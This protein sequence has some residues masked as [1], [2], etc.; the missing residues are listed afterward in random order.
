M[1]G[2]AAAGPRSACPRWATA[3]ASRPIQP[4][5]PAG[6]RGA[7]AELRRH[8]CRGP[9]G[10]AGALV[11][12]LAR[13]L[14]CCTAVLSRRRPRRRGGAASRDAARIVFSTPRY[15][16]SAERA[17]AEAEPFRVLAFYILRHIQ[18]PDE[19]ARLHQEWCQA[20]GLLGRVILAGSGVNVQ[21]SGTLRACEDYARIV[22]ERLAPG[23]EVLCK[24][25]PVPEVAFINLRVLRKEL[26]PLG[27]EQAGSY[28]LTDRGEDLEPDEWAEQMQAVRA[29]ARGHMLDVRNGY[30]WDVGHFQG[31]QRPSFDVF[32]A[33][34]LQGFGL[35]ECDKDDPVLISCTGGIRCEFFGAMLRQRG[36]RRVYKLRGGIQHYGNTVG[37]RGWGGR[38]YVFDRRDTVHV[39]AEGEAPI[40]GRCCHCGR[41]CEEL[42]N[43]CNYSCNR[44][45]TA[46]GPCIASAGGCCSATCSATAPKLRP[47]TW[48]PR[49]GRGPG[50]LLRA[51]PASDSVTGQRKSGEGEDRNEATRLQM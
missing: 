2:T 31:V 50:T 11:E 44:V 32:S 33:T 28:D 21:V 35:T 7:E 40:I 14:A 25:D 13:V 43:C 23:Q 8:R 47:F 48:E 20:G 4:L 24:L 15:F 39:G 10:A 1:R 45:V 42:W 17:R 18:D 12:A 51:L 30:E 5:Q 38:L 19:E 46:C 36:F 6:P 9:G 34:S 22:A 49:A 26:V 27:L 16:T 29:G 41:A 3:S 37:A